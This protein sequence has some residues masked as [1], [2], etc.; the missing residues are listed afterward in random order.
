[1]SVKSS[2]AK[3]FT[4]V[5]LMIVVAIIGILAAIA[6]PA[7]QDNIVRSR[8]AEGVLLASALKTDL[9][10]AVSLGEVANTVTTW[11]LKASGTGANSKFVSSILGDTLSGVIT[12]TFNSSAL[13]LRPT[14]ST[15]VFTPFVHSTSGPPQ[16]LP[17]S[18]AAG[19]HG[20]VDWACASE[21][22]VYSAQ[23]NMGSAAVGT[24]LT[25]FAPSLC[26]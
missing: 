20:V 17:V 11:N 2:K 23:M 15:L 3:G 22:N 5:E 16:L 7:Y 25:K 18:I 19:T 21:S 4:L 6:I 24:L 1:M 14:E 10:G 26:R 9:T 13:G 8:V 12:V